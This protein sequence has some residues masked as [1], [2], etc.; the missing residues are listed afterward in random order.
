MWSIVELFLN[1]ALLWIFFEVSCILL[2]NA[3][4]FS[5]PWFIW[6]AL[7]V[8]IL[9]WFLKLP[10]SDSNIVKEIFGDD[11]LAFKRI[12]LSNND[13]QDNKKQYCMRVVAHRGGGFDYPENSL[14][15]F[16]NVNSPSFLFNLPEKK[17]K[18]LHVTNNNF[19]D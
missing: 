8:T 13:N 18:I 16:R 12:N 14:A 11:H 6:G 15:A 19:L 10:Q 9:L 1:G 4:Y 5:I 17:Y 3:F 2:V 7:I